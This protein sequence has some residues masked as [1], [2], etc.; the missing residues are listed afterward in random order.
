MDLNKIVSSLASSGVLGG[1]AGGA[2][3]GALVSNKKA[4]KTAGTLLKVGGIAALG[5][6][7]WKAYQNY[8]GTNADGTATSAGSAGNVAPAASAA[9]PGV[10]QNA[11]P[12]N[13]QSLQSWQGLTEQRFALDDQDDRSGSPALLIVQA[14]VAAACADG[15][16]DEHERSTIFA[17]V[18][19]MSL[20]HEEKAMVFDT[21]ESPPSLAELCERVSS[22][23]VAAEVYLASAMAIDI[24]RVQGRM[25]LDALAFRLG[26]PPGMVAQM[27]SGLQQ[28]AASNVA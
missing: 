7:A 25:Y 23:E 12:Q 6:V 16:L 28:E 26:L 10:P 14:M 22:P 3:G 5:G 17:T 13:P 18:N 2:L 21:L 15:H 19:E 9:H 4:R 1:V 27:E 20:S 8:Q 11:L 24:E